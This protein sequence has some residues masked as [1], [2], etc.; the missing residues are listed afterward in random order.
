[1]TILQW[2]RIETP[3]IW[4]YET[5][6]KCKKKLN[7]IEKRRSKDGKDHGYYWSDLA[8]KRRKKKCDAI[9]LEIHLNFLCVFFLSINRQIKYIIIDG[10]SSPLHLHFTTYIHT[11]KMKPKSDCLMIQ[12]RLSFPLSLFLHPFRSKI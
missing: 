2:I 10:F 4:K 7:L 12:Q 6:E 1:M 11:K 5:C 8:A 3:H 9:E